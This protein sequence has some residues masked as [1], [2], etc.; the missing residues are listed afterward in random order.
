MSVALTY[1][2]VP[3]DRPERFDKALASGADAIVLDLEDAVAADRKVLARE[4]VARWIAALAP[5]SVEVWVRV[6]PGALQEADIRAVAHPRL[7]G[8][9]LPKV[10][11]AHDVEQ[12]DGLLT[13][14]CPD[15]AVSALIETAAGVFAAPAIARA[16]RMRFLQLGEVDLAADLGVEVDD[17]GTAL[18]FA[19]SRV[20]AAGVAAGID[21]PPAAVSRNFRNSDALEADTRDLARL[22]FVGRACIHPAQ[23]APVRRVFTPSSEEVGKA[24][25][26]L[27]GLEA[28]ESGVAVDEAGFLIDEAVARQARRVLERAG[29]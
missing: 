18:L 4:T 16:P 10:G 23:L 26:V 2:Y 20:I 1:L 17:D 3:G 6:N 19:R 11:S 24:R 27:A 25:A 14:L 22:G 5:G 9:W 15:A 28:A 13:E 21:P 29:R 12:V 8:V 7:T